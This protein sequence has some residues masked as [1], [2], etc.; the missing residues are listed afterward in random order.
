MTP[1][2]DIADA[3]GRAIGTTAVL[4]LIALFGGGNLDVPIAID[5]A[6]P[7]A[8]ALGNTAAAALA[9]AFGGQR[10]SVPDG[11]HFIHLKHSRQIADLMLAGTSAHEIGL[12]LGIDARAVVRHRAEAES[13]GLLAE[14]RRPAQRGPERGN[15]RTGGKYS[16]LP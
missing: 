4:R 7:L 13:L 16:V 8:R 10:L 14:G 15:S 6:H 11:E 9:A 5:A 2:P 3:L 12:A 1:S